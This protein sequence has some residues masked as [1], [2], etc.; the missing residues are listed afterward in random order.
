MWKV[1]RQLETPKIPGQGK[2]LNSEVGKDEGSKA[3]SRYLGWQHILE[4]DEQSGWISLQVQS[5]R[6]PLLHRS[7]TSRPV[8]D[9]PLLLEGVV[10]WVWSE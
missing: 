5:S 4:I 2:T 3:N 10:T 9:I 1:T 6:S 8:S 7:P